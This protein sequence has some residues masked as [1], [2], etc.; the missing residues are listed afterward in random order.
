MT[1]CITEKEFRKRIKSIVRKQH[2]VLYVFAVVILVMCIATSSMFFG[3][4]KP[5][6]PE[7]DSMSVVLKSENRIPKAAVEYAQEAIRK[8]AEGFN[9]TWKN[10]NFQLSVTEAEL[11][12]DSISTGAASENV[13]IQM[14]E[15]GFRMRLEGDAKQY[16]GEGMKYEEV[17]G[18]CWLTGYSNTD[19]VYIFLSCEEKDGEEIWTRLGMINPED[20]EFYYGTE[21]MQEKYGNIYTAAAMEIYYSAK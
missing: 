12:M 9:R 16:F 18:V 20:L 6:I 10:H 21:E 13:S 8:S 2:M 3:T 15:V 14:Y 1:Q 19:V 17:D 11:M 5:H 7:E 4:S